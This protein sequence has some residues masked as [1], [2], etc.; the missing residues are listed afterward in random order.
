MDIPSRRRIIMK[1]MSA[2]VAIIS[3]LVVTNTIA[4]IYM[5]NSIADLNRSVQSINTTVSGLKNDL[6]S[7]ESELRVV[8][9][10]YYPLLIKD[11]LGRVVTIN[12]E[13]MR[14]VSGAP[15][16]TETLFALGAA[17]KVVGVDTYSNYPNELLELKNN[18][19]IVTVGGVT[20]LDPEKVAALRPDLVLIDAGL[21]SKFV[22][23]LEGLGLTVVA[24]E[25]KSVED[26]INNIQLISK[27]TFKLEE[28]TRVVAQLKSAMQE[29]RQKVSASPPTKILYLVW[30]DP[31]YTAGKDTYINELISIA[32]GENVFS[33]RSG[34]FVVNPEDVVSARPSVII[35]SSM[36]LPKSAEALFSYFR[37]LPGFEY[38]DAI[39]NNR[40]YILT[41][42]ASNALERAGPRAADAVFILG[43]ILHPEAFNAS[44]PNFISEYATYIRR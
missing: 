6:S 33:T 17:R 1:R 28:G 36:A 35:M 43:Y 29:V 34:W 7:F 10:S 2:L 38:L 21:Q 25:S 9:E 20:T 32:G 23:A 14:I 15:S 27:V 39:K 22:P 13:P 40:V 19:T 5:T 18:G 16:I 26:I 4:V 24:V 41:G 3:L 8:K 37:T 30:P 44:L 31:M 12:S 42:E 11:A